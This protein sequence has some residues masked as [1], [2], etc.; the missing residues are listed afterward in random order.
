M[1]YLY[2][3]LRSPFWYI[4]YIDADKNKHDK[5]TGF[6]ADDPNDTIKAKVLRAEL[7]AREYQRVPMVNCAAWDYW[8]PKFFERH[9][10]TKATLDRYEDA[11]KWVALWLQ[12]NRI[13]SPRQL[14]YRLGIE[15]LEWRTTFKKRTGKTF[16]DS[17]NEIR[18]GHASRMLIDTT[19]TI[20]EIAYKCGFNNISNFNR[21]FKRK[22]FCIPKE[23]REAYTGNRVF[24]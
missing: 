13:H 21:I 1:A 3:I 23:F 10:P 15:Y 9:C 8:V 5:S 4:Q 17:L 19:N 20:A 2:L 22:K 14:T 16:I 7:E 12:N 18:L 24:I 11:W 6:R